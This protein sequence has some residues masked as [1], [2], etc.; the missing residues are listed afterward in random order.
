[1]NNLSRDAV[2]GIIALIIIALGIVWFAVA[3]PPQTPAAPANTPGAT[4][5]TGF[6]TLHITENAP[7]YTVDT[8]YPN[9]VGLPGATDIAAVAAMKQW[10]QDEIA[11][12]KI[13]GN[14]ANLTPE[15]IQVQQLGGDRKYALGI[16]YEMH[17][18]AHTISYVYQVFENT[19]GAHPNTT[20]KT[21]A[22][23]TASGKL[24][25]IADIFAPGAKHLSTL[26]DLAASKLPAQIAAAEQVDVSEVDRS[27]LDPGIAPTA[28]NFSNFYF[29]GSNF[30]I[31]FPP[32]QVGPYVLGLVTLTIPASEVS[33]LSPQYP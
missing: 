2:I 15:D 22:F 23:D 4:A 24:L 19:F 29:D 11:Q 31:L 27:M 28:E 9:T 5:V 17:T 33:G 26:H 1:M 21:F 10:E 7:Y 16:S 12:F 8:A 18:S 3:H 14:F 13:D 30:V 20:Y 32:Y 6:E 25:G